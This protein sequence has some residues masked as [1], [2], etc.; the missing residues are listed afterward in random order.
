M[1]VKTRDELMADLNEILGENNSDEALAF[2]QNM[3]DT[4][5]DSSV[6]RISELEQ[7]V[8]DVDANWRKKYRDAFFTGA[9]EKDEKDDEEEKH[10]KPRT[11][12]DLFKTE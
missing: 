1:A 7:Q 3:S 5:G 12:A 9:P 6:Q 2:I 8:K 11:F 4:L 10:K